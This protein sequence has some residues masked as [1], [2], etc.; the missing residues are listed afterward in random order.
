MIL[1][2]LCLSLCVLLSVGCAGSPYCTSPQQSPPPFCLAPFLVFFCTLSWAMRFSGAVSVV[3]LSQATAVT[4]AAPYVGRFVSQVANI[5][6]FFCSRWA[7]GPNR[8]RLIMTRPPSLAL[9]SRQQLCNATTWKASLSPIFHSRMVQYFLLGCEI[10]VRWCYKRWGEPSD[11]ISFFVDI[12]TS[13]FASHTRPRVPPL[14]TSTV[15]DT[16]MAWKE[17]EK[18][19]RLSRAPES[20][21]SA[22]APG[23]EASAT[24]AHSPLIA[25]Y[26]EAAAAERV[27]FRTLG[28]H[29]GVA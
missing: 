13:A 6:L 18:R 24:G 28:R 4:S 1:L 2:G 22:G 10:D 8:A 14:A 20:R 26:L 29:R 27:R 21:P 17:N 19:T 7:G 23:R 25:S 15:Y 16:C 3:P 9:V 11:V 5:P 12:L